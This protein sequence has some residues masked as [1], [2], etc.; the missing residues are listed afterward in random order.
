MQNFF[1]PKFAKPIALIIPDSDSNILGEGFP[2]LG[3][4]VI[5]LVITQPNLD[6]STNFSLHLHIQMFHLQQL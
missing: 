6:K 1:T 5:D 2:I 4:K 3:S